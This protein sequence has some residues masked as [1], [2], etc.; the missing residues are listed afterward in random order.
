MLQ[1]QYHFKRT[2]NVSRYV[3]RMTCYISNICHAIEGLESTL[4]V[5]FRAWMQGRIGAKL[6]VL[7]RYYNHWYNEELKILQLSFSRGQPSNSSVTFLTAPN[8]HT[9]PTPTPFGFQEEARLPPRPKSH[10]SFQL[11][12]TERPLSNE[13]YSLW[14]ILPQRWI[15]LIMEN[16]FLAHAPGQDS[17]R[18]EPWDHI[19]TP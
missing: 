18:S 4:H 8:E 14:D 10:N 1:R 19:H 16:T 7:P 3:P 6:H 13:I 11:H 15:G 5:C 12:I 9:Y 2:Y 17:A